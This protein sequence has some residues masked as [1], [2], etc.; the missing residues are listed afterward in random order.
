MYSCAMLTLQDLLRTIE[1]HLAD[2]GETATA[3]GRRVANDGN[4]VPDLRAGRT[5]SLRLAA[6]LVQACEPDP[7]P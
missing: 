1:R 2:S 4:L 5:P 6:K 7:T 3:F